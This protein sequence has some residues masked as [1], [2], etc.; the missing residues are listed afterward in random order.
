MTVTTTSNKVRFLG[1]SSTTVFAYNYI[2]TAADQLSV[3]IADPTDI[4]TVLTLDTH[5]TV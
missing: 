3:I 1:N 4:A 5:Y 2:I